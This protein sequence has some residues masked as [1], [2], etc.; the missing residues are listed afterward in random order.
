MPRCDHPRTQKLL[1][2]L[3]VPLVVFLIDL[4]LHVVWCQAIACQNL[5]KE[6]IDFKTNENNSETYI[7]DKVGDTV[8]I[9]AYKLP[10]LFVDL[11]PITPLP[12]LLVDRFLLVGDLFLVFG[13][14]EQTHCF[15]RYDYQSFLP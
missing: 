5:N 15:I 2:H 8:P 13:C 1:R 10:V 14:V 12:L 7:L 3:I 4:P 6:V 11:L 9:L